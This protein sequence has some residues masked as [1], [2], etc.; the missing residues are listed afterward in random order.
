MGSSK[1]KSTSSGSTT[2]TSTSTSTSTPDVPVWAQT[3]TQDY[4][5]QIGNF[6]QALSQ[7]PNMFATPANGL[8]QHAYNQAFQLPSGA[9][10]LGQANALASQVGN[11]AAPTYSAPT[12]DPVTKV[13]NVGVTSATL[14]PAQQ[15][16]LSQAAAP[17]RATLT[18][19]Q[20]AKL[21]P[22]A[23]AALAQAQAV[24]AGPAASLLDNF[25]AY[26]NP[27][28][29]ELVTQNLAAYDEGA[30]RNTA[31]AQAAA[32]RAGAFG[33]S[34]AGLAQAQLASEQASGR[35]L[36]SANLRSNAFNQQ[37]ALAEADAGRRQQTG[38]LDASNA[39]QT[40]WNNAG[41]ANQ[42]NQFNAGQ[43]NDFAKTRAQL[44][45]EASLFNAGQANQNSM[46]N[47]GQ[48][49]Q[50]NQF[51]AGL[52]SQNSQFNAGQANDFAQ[53][54]A[55]FNQQSNMQAAQIAAAQQQADAQA[56][57]Q[58]ASQQAQ[59][60]AQGGMFNVGTQM[61]Q[62]G[63]ALSAA[64]LLSSNAGLGSSIANNNLAAQMNAGN[65]MY[66]IDQQN[67]LAGLAGLQAYGGLL[68]PALYSQFVGQ[69]NTGTENTSGTIQGTEISKN[70][71]GLLGTLLQLG[72]R[73][74][75]AYAAGG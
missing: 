49:T 39:Q 36:L 62:R 12:I 73:A 17:E 69:T 35:G 47:A 32:A 68:N 28:T 22:A 8:Q 37:A 40:N 46:F 10:S 59:L 57:N 33:G 3:P 67:N 27:V 24:K 63:Q 44:A 75:S 65:A 4:F 30:A 61:D 55:G 34:R 1:T 19:A 2:G 58:R 66:G 15:A 20:A 38:L 26:A 23:Q 7:N 5:S 72:N 13:G 60:Q 74:A 25:A 9:E 71:Q 16:G 11:A 51:N 54:Q 52:A 21:G 42:N 70:K 48:T 41:W 14:G 18:Q 56:A 53:T 31:A 45:Q 50:N 64:G 43:K 6:G 29:N